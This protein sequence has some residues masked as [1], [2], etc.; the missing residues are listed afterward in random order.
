MRLLALVHVEKCY[1]N[2]F[3]A[4]VAGSLKDIMEKDSEGDS[5]REGD[6]RSPLLTD[7]IILNGRIS[8]ILLFQ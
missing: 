6:Y 1:K 4:R 7:C 8:C 5:R 3:L 2:T